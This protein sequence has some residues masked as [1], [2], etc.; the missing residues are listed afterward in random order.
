VDGE[1]RVRAIVFARR[2]GAEGGFGVPVQLVNQLVRDA[3]QAYPLGT[4]CVDS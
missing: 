1:G 4:T 2:A 3:G